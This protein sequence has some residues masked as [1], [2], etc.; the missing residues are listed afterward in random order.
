MKC[1]ERRW[2]SRA[3]SGSTK[4]HRT[5]LR[6]QKV[7]QRI[8]AARLF[9]YEPSVRFRVIARYFSIDY[10]PP[11]RLR[12]RPPAITLQPST[13]RHLQSFS[14]V[15]CRVFT[16]FDSTFFKYTHFFHLKYKLFFIAAIIKNGVLHIW[17]FVLSPK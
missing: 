9:S 7:F 13:M 15:F 16:S 5:C 17:T 11:R 4:C 1:C 2:A 12:I 6:K 3:P 8:T 10:T 14:R